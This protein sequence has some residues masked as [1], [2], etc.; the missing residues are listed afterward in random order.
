MRKVLATTAVTAGIVLAVAAC[1]DSG[2]SS[3]STTTKAKEQAAAALVKLPGKTNNKGTKDLST[4]GAS[5]S[6]E[7]EQDDYYFE[8]TFM[9]VAPGQKVTLELHNE[10]KATHTFTSTQLGVDKEVAPDSKATVTVTMPMSGTATFFCR[11][12]QS[13]GMQGAFVV[14]S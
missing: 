3:S 2:S 11:F 8:P 1:S 6:T 5:T 13:L 4:K 10:G 9:K 7:V 14:S 12:H